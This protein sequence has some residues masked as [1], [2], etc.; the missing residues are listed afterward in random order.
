MNVLR[1]ND[2]IEP[3]MGRISCPFW[4][5][6]VNKVYNNRYV[7]LFEYDLTLVKISDYSKTVNI[8]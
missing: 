1:A 6:Y 7:R 4:Q 8:F 2:A 5:L 3:F